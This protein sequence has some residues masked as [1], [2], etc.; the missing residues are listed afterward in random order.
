MG[1]QGKGSSE[2]EVGVQV[3]WLVTGSV[4]ASEMQLRFLWFMNLLNSSVLG[5]LPRLPTF[6]AALQ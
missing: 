1:R 6:C 3:I 2:E 5:S 4:C